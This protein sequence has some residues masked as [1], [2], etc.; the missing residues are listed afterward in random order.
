MSSQS[1]GGFWN[2]LRTIGR[3]INIVRLVIINIV[4]FLILALIAAALNRSAPN[5]ENKSALLLKPDGQLV[6]QYSIDPASRALARISGEQ[7]GQ[8]QVRDL[9]RAINAA[10]KDSRIQRILLQPDRL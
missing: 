9:V 8:V 10:A 6:E 5:V 2:G 3:A 7:T 4:F 1:T